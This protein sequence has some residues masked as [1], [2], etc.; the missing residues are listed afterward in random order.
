MMAS[1]EQ[2]E[3][4]KK[5]TEDKT[6]SVPFAIGQIKENITVNTNTPS[7]PSKEQIINQA[8][9][10]HSVG[11]ISDAAKYYQHLI[12]QGS[13]DHRVISNYG[14]I[15]QSLGKF[16]EAVLAHKKALEL[17][18]NY[19]M[20]HFNLGSVLKDMKQLKEAELATRKAIEI[21]AD[22]PKAHANL[23]GILKDLGK[24]EEAELFTRKALQLNKN[25]KIL[26]FLVPQSLLC[27]FFFLAILLR[28]LLKESL[29]SKLMIISNFD[30]T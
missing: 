21:K 29:Q 18:P 13:K 2:G 25:L 23:G 20:A 10:L 26:I 1:R 16:K 14:T 5:I 17:S 15:L 12:D 27:L 6:F 30:K 11:K 4:N 24:L 3:G 19:A 8:I 9:K 22:D 7:K 28:S